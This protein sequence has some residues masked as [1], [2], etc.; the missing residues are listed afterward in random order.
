[1]MD[2]IDLAPFR[3]A[4]DAVYDGADATKAWDLAGMK[5]VRSA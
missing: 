1:V 3:A 4:A 2:E 5:R